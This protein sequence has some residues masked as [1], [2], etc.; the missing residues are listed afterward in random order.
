LRP[1]EASSG[2]RSIVQQS[3]SHV[4]IIRETVRPLLSGAAF[5]IILLVSPR[6]QAMMTSLPTDTKTQP[7]IPASLPHEF[8]RLPQVSVIP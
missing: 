8:E 6:T 1:D 5:I 3:E 4:D 7:S 2:G